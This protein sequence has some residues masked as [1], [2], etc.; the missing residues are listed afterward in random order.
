MKSNAAYVGVLG[1]KRN[2]PKR[3]EAMRELGVSEEQLKKLHAPIGL[4]I[5]AVQPEEIALSILSEMVAVLH[6]HD[7]SAEIHKKSVI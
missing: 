3:L 2:V 6:G 1:T 4:E 7:R 5:G